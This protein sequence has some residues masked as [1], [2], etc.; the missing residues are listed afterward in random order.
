MITLKEAREKARLSTAD[1][2]S[3]L[4]VS[5]QSI[6]NWETGKRKPNKATIHM[7]AELYKVSEEKLIT[8]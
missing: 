1:V 8:K 7:L 5:T 3:Y 6:Y 2:A 4:H